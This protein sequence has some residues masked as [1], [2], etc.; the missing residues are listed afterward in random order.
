MTNCQ[1]KILA[2]DDEPI[3]L[4]LIK[5]NIENEGYSVDICNSEEEALNLNLSTYNLIIL[6]VDIDATNSCELIN[7][8]KHNS[9]SSHTPIIILSEKK[10]K[11]NAIDWL[12]LGA[13]DYIIKPLSMPGLTAR[14]K[15]LLRRCNI[16]K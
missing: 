2:I 16:G 11:Q 13:D 15:S 9:I 5:Y 1:G 4:D 14:I 8:I 7:F 10:S 3:I 12:R 6:D